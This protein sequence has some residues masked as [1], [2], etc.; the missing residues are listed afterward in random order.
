MS[1]PTTQCI[2]VES[3]RKIHPNN[4]LK[5]WMKNQNH[6]YVG[7][8]GRIFIHKGAAEKEIFHYKESK[9]HNPFKVGKKTGEYS[10]TESLQLFENYVLTSHLKNDLGELEGKV[11]GCF[12]DQSKGCHAKVLVKL[13]NDRKN[14]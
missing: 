13:Y 14:I 7:R 8:R 3:L 10:L 11:L 12:C 5:E 9:W 1:E 6:L 2:K 4:N